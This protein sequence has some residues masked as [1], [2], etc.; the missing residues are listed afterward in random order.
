VRQF[1][2]F[3]RRFFNLILFLGIEIVCLVLIARTKTLQGN[4][5]TNSANAVSGYFYNKQNDLVYY[6]GLRKMNDSLLGENARLHDRLAKLQSF[7]SIN[8]TIGKLPVN[9]ND[10]G[11]LV[12]FAEY[13]YRS[14][15]VINNSVVSANNY[16]TISRG[17]EDG[18]RKNM[19]V[20]SGT[21]LVGKVEHVSKHYA[22]ILS[23]LSVKQQVSAK[24]KDGNFSFVTWEG[25]KPDVL[26]MRGLPPEIK[27]KRNDSVFT[28]GYSQYLPANI[29]IGTVLK[30]ES[31]KKDNSQQLYIRPAT[32]FRNLQY[33]F[34]IEDKMLN[35]RILLEDSATAIK[36]KK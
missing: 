31:L 25:E 24:L 15:R 7:D 12:R 2:L 10:T 36:P 3:I 28:T 9:L 14:A 33:V 32:N 6:F 19:A 30:I 11:K 27:V 22:T 4:D 13:V 5:L 29:L 8:N 21:G 23:I 26:L 1:I 35:E 20:V 16:I 34:L 17:S 18:I